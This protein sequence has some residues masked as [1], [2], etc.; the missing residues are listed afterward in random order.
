MKAFHK[1]S[2]PISKTWRRD[3]VKKTFIVAVLLFIVLCTGFC[4][5][6]DKFEPTNLESAIIGSGEVSTTIVT[7]SD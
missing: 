5:L 6:E 7:K 1:D 2:W 3:K 4:I